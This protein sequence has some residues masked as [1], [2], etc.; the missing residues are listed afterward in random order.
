MTF[1][2]TYVRS[3]PDRMIQIL[4]QSAASGD[5]DEKSIVES[6]RSFRAL[7]DR[8]RLNATPD[9]VRVF[10]VRSTGS[11]DTVVTSFGRLAVDTLEASILNNAELNDTV[12]AGELIKIV[13]PGRRN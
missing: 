4:G 7:T 9:R 5:S 1:L 3:A 8:A 6:M 12:R 2:A 10:K 13:E 11:F